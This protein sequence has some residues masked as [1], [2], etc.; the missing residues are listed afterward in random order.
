MSQRNIKPRFEVEEIDKEVE[1]VV[2][3]KDDEGNLTQ[4][5]LKEPF[6]YMVYFPTGASIRVRTEAELRRLGFDRDPML[7]DLE[8][9]DEV[10]VS[11]TG[12]LKKLAQQKS[13]RSKS[14]QRAATANVGD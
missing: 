10:G 3:E 13:S 14:A 6:G 12:S 4:K 2:Y 8:T 9:G 5:T 1:H 11:Q 7:I